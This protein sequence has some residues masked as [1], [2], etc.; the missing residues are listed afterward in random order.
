MDSSSIKKIV[1]GSFPKI[2]FYSK[3]GNLILSDNCFELLKTYTDSLYKTDTFKVIKSNALQEELKNA[4]TFDGQ[5][6]NLNLPHSDYVVVYY[7]ATWMGKLNRDRLGWLEKR[8]NTDK[9]K[10]ITVVK[11]NSDLQKSWNW[12]D[13]KY[14]EIFEVKP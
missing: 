5:L 10:N 6:V 12:P 11:I 4:R 7:W 9:R 3:T 1:T 14:E 8:A 2:H 13:K